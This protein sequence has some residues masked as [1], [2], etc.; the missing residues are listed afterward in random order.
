MLSENDFGA[1]DG[2]HRSTA[3][4]PLPCHNIG[5]PPKRM[6]FVRMAPGSAFRPNIRS[7]LGRQFARSDQRS[8]HAGPTLDN[9]EL[10]LLEID[11]FQSGPY[12]ENRSCLIR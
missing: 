3:F 2:F 9:V 11:A 4:G 8:D 5:N 10:S 1:V 7:T 12:I 6:R